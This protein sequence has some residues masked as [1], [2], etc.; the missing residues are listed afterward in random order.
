MKSRTYKKWDVHHHIVPDFYVDEMKKMGISVAGIETTGV[1]G[2][3][4]KGF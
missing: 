3:C 1:F 4:F 2:H